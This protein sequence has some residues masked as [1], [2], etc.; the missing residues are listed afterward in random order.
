V[1]IL[2]VDDSRVTR[3]YIADMLR[4]AGYHQIIEADSVDDA[5]RKT[6][7]DEPGDV[8]VPVD[9][10]LMDIH[11]PGKDGIQ[12]CREFKERKR[13]EDIPV[14]IISG[15]EQLKNFE[16]AFEA[17]AVDYLTKPPNRLELLVRVRAALRLK[18]E[19]D[20]RK[21]R[22]REL[23][24]LTKRLEEANRELR[25]ISTLDALT[26]I[27][28]RHYCNEF[29]EREWRRAIRDGKEFAVVMIDI[30][31]FKAYNDLYGHLAGDDC[32]KKVAGALQRGVR[33][34]G[35]L[36]ARYGGEE[37]IVL[38]PATDL[39]GAVKVAEAIHKGVVALQLRHKGSKVARHVT[40]SI[41]C[42]SMIPGKDSVA[43]RLIGAADAALYEA[44]QKGRNRVALT[45]PGL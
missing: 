26:G 32:L 24:T 27:A 3:M 9:L 4:D 23:V 17:G 30:D 11:M 31:F 34:P 2:I 13:F 6:C 35:D 37:F 7:P 15:I 36:L 8:C 22:E 33:R 45:A 10:I 44:K 43:E 20:R 12:G 5:F 42:A 16:H 25:R 39:D 18:S 40:V 41:G 1:N 28:N 19:M 38:L 29:L 21:G 14:I